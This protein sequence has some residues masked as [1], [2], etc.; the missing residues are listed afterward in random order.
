[1]RL[2][3]SNLNSISCLS[4]GTINR[5]RIDFEQEL[6]SS[7]RILRRMETLFDSIAF[8]NVCFNVC[9]KDNLEM[10][11]IMKIQSSTMANDNEYSLMRLT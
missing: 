9:S 3:R 5:H 4:L 10:I 6:F 1:M 2:K 11:Q 8:F 7:P